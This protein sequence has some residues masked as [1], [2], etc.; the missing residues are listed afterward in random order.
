MIILPSPGRLDP[1]FLFGLR[2]QLPSPQNRRV[3]DI[4]AAM[5]IVIVLVLRTDAAHGSSVHVHVGI[6]D[7]G[8]EIWVVF[9]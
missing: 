9:N 6:R 5:D 1:F 7:V 8:V 4:V 3:V 2:R